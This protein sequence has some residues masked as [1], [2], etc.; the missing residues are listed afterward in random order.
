MINATCQ[1]AGI[2]GVNLSH[3]F[4]LNSTSTPSPKE[5]KSG[6][7]QWAPDLLQILLLSRTIDFAQRIGSANG[8]DIN[9]R[10]DRPRCYCNY[11]YYLFIFCITFITR[12]ADRPRTAREDT[13]RPKRRSITSVYS[14]ITVVAGPH[15]SSPPAHS[16]NEEPSNTLCTTTLAICLMPGLGLGFFRFGF[17]F[18]RGAGQH[19]LHSYLCHLLDACVHACKHAPTYPSVR[20]LLAARAHARAARTRAAHMRKA[21]GRHSAGGHRVPC[22]SMGAARGGAPQR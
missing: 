13:E 4:P 8:E 14:S 18:E 2:A 3:T 16:T 17:K 10:A 20:P 9:R 21:R 5:K 1:V 15:S 7:A 12:R 6:S 11:Y 22:P 19:A